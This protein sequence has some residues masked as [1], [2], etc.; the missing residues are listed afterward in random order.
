MTLG[1]SHGLL[2]KANMMLMTKAATEKNRSLKI[3]LLISSKN[4]EE[5]LSGERVWR[6]EGYFSDTRHELNL[7]EKNIS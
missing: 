6:S 4:S 5:K 2:E 7:E 1:K 3:Q